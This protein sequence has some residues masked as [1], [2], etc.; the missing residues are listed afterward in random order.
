MPRPDVSDERIP[1]ILN[2]ALKVFN[3]KGLAAARM[4][5]IAREAKLSIGGV[6]WYYK[7]KDEVVLA[8]MD[9]VIDEDVAVLTSLLNEQGTVRERLLGYVRATAK[10]GTEYLPL[11]YELYGE[12]Q[13]NLKVRKHIQKYLQHYRGA[14]AQIIQQG[15]DGREI[16]GGDANAIAITLAAV[17]EGTLELALLDPTGVDAEQATIQAVGFIFDGISA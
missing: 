5:D 16:R 3:C 1:Q 17:Y 13:R 9:K 14:L 11:I 7:G 10:D 2:A 15:M 4:E 6:Y 8:I 12:S